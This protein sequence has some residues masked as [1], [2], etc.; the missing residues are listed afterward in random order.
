MYWPTA[1]Q[2][3]FAEAGEHSNSSNNS[4]LTIVNESPSQVSERLRDQEF[5]TRKFV[6]P[7]FAYDARLDSSSNETHNNLTIALQNSNPFRL[8]AAPD[9]YAYYKSAEAAEEIIN[10][11]ITRGR[12]LTVFSSDDTGTIETGTFQ[13]DVLFFK[14]AHGSR[15]VFASA[16]DAQ[17]FRNP[18]IFI[19]PEEYRARD[20]FG[21]ETSMMSKDIP[22]YPP[23]RVSVGGNTSDASSF[24]NLEQD[25]NNQLQ[26]EFDTYYNY[27]DVDAELQETITDANNELALE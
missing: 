3:R 25:A 1:F 7:Y 23:G 2:D 4:S 13:D 12:E 11:L 19:A 8:E 9:E 18:L 26:R 6:D 21:Y 16:E 15:Y 5:A 10:Q 14:Q 24:D 22:V 27:T 20:D 17:D